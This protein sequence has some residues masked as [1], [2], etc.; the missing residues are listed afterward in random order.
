MNA[1][2]TT[3]LILIGAALL[4]G[5]SLI[6]S[7]LKDSIAAKKHSDSSDFEIRWEDEREEKKRELE[8]IYFLILGILL[9]LSCIAFLVAFLIEPM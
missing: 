3:F 9:L 7:R 4:T 6:V 1:F 8:G 5:I 2:N